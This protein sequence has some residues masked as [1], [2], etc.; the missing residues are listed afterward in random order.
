[1]AGYVGEV[2]ERITVVVTLANAYEYATYY[3]WRKQDNY[4]YTMT[5]EDGHVLVWKTTSFMAIDGQ[6]E[7]GRY[8][9]YAIRKNDKIRI[10]ATVKA[11]GEYKE[12]EQTELQR[13]KIMELVEKAITKEE[14]Q[15]AKQKEQR[16]SL[17]GGDFIW[18]MPY[19]QYKEH[20]ADCET[21]AGSYESRDGHHVAQISVIIREGRLKASGVRGEHYSGYQMTNELGEYITYR[22]VSEDNALK[23]VNKD[24][25]NHSWECTKIYDYNN[26]YK[27]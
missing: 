2:G 11:H 4:I 6:D 19:K 10:K 21:L 18:R 15:E 16:E 25:P 27:R 26:H 23:R 24:F 13:V 7:R 5:D 1:M 22:A 3:G 14:M 20:Y 12:Q 8:C 9:P 17:Q